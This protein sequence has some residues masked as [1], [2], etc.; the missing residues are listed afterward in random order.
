MFKNNNFFCKTIIT[1][2]KKIFNKIFRKSITNFEGQQQINQKYKIKKSIFQPISLKV[3]EKI[4]FF[5]IIENL[6]LKF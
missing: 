4:I 3:K 5:K 1:I 6:S 2:Q